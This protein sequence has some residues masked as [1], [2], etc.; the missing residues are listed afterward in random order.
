MTCFYHLKGKL[1]DLR[2]LRE[3]TEKETAKRIK[4]R[5]DSLILGLEDIYEGYYLV[6]EERDN[7]I[8]TTL[9][10]NMIPHAWHYRGINNYLHETELR[11]LNN[12]ISERA[13]YK[14]EFC[15]ASGAKLTYS[16]WDYDFAIRVRKLVRFVSTCDKCYNVCRYGLAKIT[17]KYEE[18]REHL[19][20]VL[21]ITDS[22]VD[23]IIKQQEDQ[24]YHQNNVKWTSDFSILNDNGYTILI[25]Q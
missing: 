22:E 9:T 3:C 12:R 2:Y 6:G 24:A 16:H 5:I 14:C 23:R 17:N 7:P 15:G 10:P 8:H 20:K 4:Q 1:D 19:K 13:K 11:D 21:K 25:H 18:A